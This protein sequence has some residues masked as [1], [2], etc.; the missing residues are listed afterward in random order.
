MSKKKKKNQILIVKKFKPWKTTL[1]IIGGSLITPLPPTC[2]ILCKK[3]E[4]K[5]DKKGLLDKKFCINRRVWTNKRVDGCPIFEMYPQYFDI[6]H[7]DVCTLRHTNIFV[8][9]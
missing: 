3:E 2:T 8:R 6:Y 4:I 1:Q 5:S 9:V 7:T